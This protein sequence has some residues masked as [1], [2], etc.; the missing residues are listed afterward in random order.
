MK[1][2]GRPVMRHVHKRAAFGRPLSF[3]LGSMVIYLNAGPGLGFCCTPSK[4][5][6]AALT[7]LVP[8]APPS[9]WTGWW[10]LGIIASASNDMFF[11]KFEADRRPRC[12]IPAMVNR[13]LVE[14]VSGM[15]CCRYT[16]DG[17]SQRG[18]R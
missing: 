5:H 12:V 16:D 14:I 17:L 8:R 2:F 18:H 1:N 9:I 7:T 11:D 13:S 6:R 15:T 3:V 4:Q 10:W